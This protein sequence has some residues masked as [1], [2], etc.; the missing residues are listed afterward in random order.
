MATRMATHVATRMATRMSSLTSNLFL[1]F[2]S[3]K[4]RKSR[5]TEVACS[6]RNKSNHGS[7]YQ[8]RIS[9]C[10]GTPEF[11][12]VLLSWHRFLAFA[13]SST[14]WGLLSPDRH[15]KQHLD[16]QEMECESTIQN[17]YHPSNNFWKTAAIYLN[18]HTHFRAGRETGLRY[19][20]FGFERS[21]PPA[22][23]S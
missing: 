7:H 16:L 8:A 19:Y 5:H 18:F 6:K 12:Y 22:L 3:K 21:F 9:L 11:C 4:S 2:D 23:G 10:Q 17:S 15:H 1:C 20:R 14:Q 13:L